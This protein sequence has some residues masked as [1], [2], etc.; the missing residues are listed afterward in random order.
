MIASV[1]APD[2]PP[3]LLQPIASGEAGEAPHP[4]REENHN[5]LI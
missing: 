2:S 5:Q 3:H 1:G 4:R